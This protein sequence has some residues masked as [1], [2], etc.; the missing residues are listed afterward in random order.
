MNDPI[1]EYTKGKGWQVQGSNTRYITLNNKRVRLTIR[2]PNPGEHFIQIG[3]THPT[4]VS[5]GVIDMERV[6][7]W[8]VTINRK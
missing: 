7:D 4:L 6:E 5:N 2:D 1:Y 3:K 8:L